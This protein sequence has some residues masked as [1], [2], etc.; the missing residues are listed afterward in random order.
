MITLQ[1]NFEKQL[2]NGKEEKVEKGDWKKRNRDL[3]MYSDSVS[4]NATENLQKIAEEQVGIRN[5]W[6]YLG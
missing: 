2:S 3:W 4:E 5:W 6:S 1:E